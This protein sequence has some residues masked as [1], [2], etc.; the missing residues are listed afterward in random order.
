MFT[1][2]KSASMPQSSGSRASTSNAPMQN[3]IRSASSKPTARSAPSIISADMSITGSVTSDGEMQIDGRIDGDVAAISIT[4]GQTGTIQ[5]EVK[6]QTV[7]V[8]GRIVGSIRARKVEL[9]TGAHVEGD[10]VHASLSIQS[11]AVFQGQVKH[12][13]NP[14]QS[15]ANGTVEATQPAPATAPTPPNANGSAVE[16]NGLTN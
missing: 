10:I 9:E 1:K 8:R 2:N 14:L 5:G 11:N 3:A 4:I 16:K 13:D 6:A 15:A 12:A 7:I